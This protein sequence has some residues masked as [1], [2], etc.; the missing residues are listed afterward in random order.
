MNNKNGMFHATCTCR[1][2]AMYE[3]SCGY[4]YKVIQFFQQKHKSFMQQKAML[5]TFDML[6]EFLKLHIVLDFMESHIKKLLII[7]SGYGN[8]KFM[9]NEDLVEVLPLFV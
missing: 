7:P 6:P 4:M 3:H 2:F 5:L 1:M 9:K 8:V